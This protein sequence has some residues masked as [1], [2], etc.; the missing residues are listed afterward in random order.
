MRIP[1]PTR[2]ELHRLAELAVP[3]TLVQLGLQGLGVADSMIVGR[4]SAAA[5]AGIAIGSVYFF[6]IG[7][8]GLGLLLGLEPLISQAVGAREPDAVARAFQRGLVLVAV[9]GTLS[10]LS[11]VPSD[12]ILR[13]IGQPPV[14]A[15]IAGPYLRVQAPSIYAFLLFSLMRILLQARGIIRPIVIAIVAA[16]VVNIVLCFALVFG[17]LGLPALGPIGAG[18][19]TTIA[20]FVMVFGLIAGSWSELRPLLAWRRDTLVAG[21]MWRV[22]QL[23]APVGAQI[24][25]EF[26]VFAVIGLVMGNLGAVPMAAHQIAINIASLTYMV[27]LGVGTAGSVLVGRA[28]GAGDPAAARRVAVAA[29]TCGVGFMALSAI[30]LVFAPGWIARAYTNDAATIAMASTLI[31]IAGVFQVF[32]G[33]QVVS[34]G[35][36]RGTGDTRTPMIVNLVGYW[37]IGLPISL[38]FARSLHM[39]PRGLWWGIVVS[40]ATV[41]LIVATRVRIRL[42]G[43]LERLR[44]EGEREATAT[45]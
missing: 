29:L 1:R 12:R 44:V 42:G 36:L 7:S 24:M 20:R 23:G 37:C 17:G 19:A 15:D 13:L 16:N 41:G 43:N 38:W 39:G 6:A 10:A 28:I 8:F 4:Y 32:D 11:F 9:M 35:V 31:P 45:E 27:P 14:I 22:L 34:I 26:G 25:L 30:V 21:P 3:V 18:I 2:Q 5:L 33:L 40:L